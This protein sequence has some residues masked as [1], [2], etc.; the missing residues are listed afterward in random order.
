MAFFE[1]KDIV[2]GF[3]STF[4]LMWNDQGSGSKRNGAYWRPI[5]PPEMKDFHVL[6][7]LGRDDYSDVNG[8]TPV[9]V[10]KDAKGSSGTALRPPTKFQR[11]WTDSG[12]GAKRDGAMWRPIP[13]DGYVALGLICTNGSTPSTD[14]IS[15][16]RSD[17][18]VAAYPDGLIWDDTGTGAK[19]DFGSWGIEAPAAP[20]GEA[21]FTAGTFIGVASHTKPTKDPNSYVL[22]L[23][24][25]QETPNNPT[26]PAPVLQGFSK[27]SPFEKDTVTYSSILPWFSVSDPNLTPVTQLVKSPQYRLDR[28]DRY[29]LIGFGYNTTSTSQE[30]TWSFSKGTSGSDSKTFSETTGI[31]FGLEWGSGPLGAGKASVKLSQSFTHTEST[32]KGWNESETKTVKAVVPDGKAVAVYSIQSSYQLFRADGTEVSTKVVYDSSD[33]LYW[34]E[35][36]PKPSLEVKVMIDEQ[37]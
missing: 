35:F 30:F 20:A 3:T 11:V 21:F 32:T 34:T 17:L 25:P 22:R 15:C 29:K 26:P 28:V 14:D 4:K 12:S 27:P 2:I 9:A 5:L 33:N 10:V 7:D 18:V 19:S 16:L 13:P 36:P 24:I 6:G 37:K 1:Y 31:E 23:L 8:K